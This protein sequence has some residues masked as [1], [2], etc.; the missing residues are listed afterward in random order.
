MRLRRERKAA[1]LTQTELSRRSKVPQGTISKLER[2]VILLP[3]FETLNRLAVT[4]QK[5]GRRVTEVQL[6]PR[7]QPLL[8]K[9]ARAERPSK[10]V[11]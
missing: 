2:G 4:L 9:G 3:S 11:A 7:R 1:K 8:I 5:C 6:Q 10:R